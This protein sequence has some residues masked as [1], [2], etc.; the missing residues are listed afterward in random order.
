MDPA[1]V[2]TYLSS[3]GQQ[4]GGQGGGGNVQAMLA[5]LRQ[6][7]YGPQ[8]LQGLQTLQQ[9][10]GAATDGRPAWQ[11][12]ADAGIQGT[13]SAAG[14]RAALEALQGGQ[15]TVGGGRFAVP[16]TSP[17]EPVKDP[18]SVL[19][20][21][22]RRSPGTR[23]PGIGQGAPFIPADDTPWTRDPGFQQVAQQAEQR[24]A[25]ARGGSPFAPYLDNFRQNTAGMSP[26]EIQ[27]QMAGT[28]APGGSYGADGVMRELP[29]TLPMPDGQPQ[30][31]NGGGL[32]AP[33]PPVPPGL[34]PALQGAQSP[35]PAPAPPATGAANVSAAMLGADQF[36]GPNA[37][38]I[39]NARAGIFNNVR[40][41]LRAP[42]YAVPA[43]GGAGGGKVGL[44]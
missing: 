7:L 5:N 25:Q 40:Q 4:G 42:R 33:P 19:A 32:Q 11:Q 18:A 23:D 1:A 24:I 16:M 3:L 20:G 35:S 39:M 17:N 38:R 22:D 31:M 9:G 2:R 10:G 27:F 37:R 26:Q 15:P 28:P 8:A 41:A 13:G 21:T 43:A 36:Q 12:L 6:R 29:A 44:K 30:A 14:N 34:K